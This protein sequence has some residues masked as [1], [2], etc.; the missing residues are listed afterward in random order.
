M[1]LSIAKFF[2]KA[3]RNDSTLL[4]AVDGRIFPV[5]RSMED[6]EADKIP[7]LIVAPQAINADPGT[8]DGMEGYGDSCTVSIMVVASTYEKMVDLAE[9]IR[10]D[11]QTAYDEDLDDSS[12]NF[13]I[14]DYQFSADPPQLD[15]TKPC[16]Y[17]T[18]R[19]QCS[20]FRK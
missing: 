1:S 9:R 18:L 6:E 2:V 12:W 15:P 3:L 11:I 20:T 4:S 7:Y 17:M 13:T 10:S 5:A 8:K 16:Y 19:Y 14:E